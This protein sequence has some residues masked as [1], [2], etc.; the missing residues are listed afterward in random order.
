MNPRRTDANVWLP[1]QYALMIG[2]GLS[3]AGWAARPVQHRWVRVV[4][5]FVWEAVT[6]LVLYALW[7]WAG[8]FD[9]MDS[10]GA[11]GRGEL[12]LR[13]QD[14]MPLPTELQMQRWILPHPWVVQ[15]A[16]V[17][18]AVAHVPAM[19]AALVWLFVWHRP[20]YRA[21][22]NV[23]ALTTAACLVGHLVT[24]APPRL[25]PGAGFVDTALLYNQSVYG[26][27][28]SGVSEQLAAMPSVHVLWAALVAVAAL[29]AGRSRWRWIGPGHA[30]LTLW[31][32]GVTANH[33]WLD[34]FVAMVLIPPA[35][36]LQEVACRWWDRRAKLW[37]ADPAP[38]ETP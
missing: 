38:G 4:R 26:P 15:A 3:V 7:M 33:Y 13:W 12:L 11:V 6:V 9:V 21:V 24:V 5:P 23:L 18:Y 36:W 34:G 1:W 35:W 17:Y 27:P 14:W 10:A 30:A 8:R 20:H 19:I 22:R 28:G 25:L 16:N 2:G 32:V 29:R 31:V 37:V